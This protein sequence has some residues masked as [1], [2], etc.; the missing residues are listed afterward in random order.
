MIGKDKHITD[1]LHL[2][3][4]VVILGFTG[5]IGKLISLP[6][7]EMVWYRMLFAFI[8][9]FIWLKFTGKLVVPD[10]KNLVKY[11]ATGFIVAFHW[12]AFFGSI[13]SSTVSVALACFASTALFTSLLEPLFNKSKISFLEFFL[14]LIIIGAI[15]IIFKFESEYTLGII[16]GLASAVLGALF[17]VLNKRFQ[18]EYKPVTITLF[19]MAGGFIALS[20][21]LPVYAAFTPVT[22]ALNLSDLFW[23][24]ILS[25]LCTAY[26]FMASIHVMRSLSAFQVVL[27]INM[28]PVYG[29]FLAFLIFGESELMTPGF[30]FGTVLLVLAVFTYSLL[31][32]K[33]RTVNL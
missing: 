22:L 32:R 8:G 17:M 15:V 19:E 11:L 1:V 33:P 21:F 16:S 23:L 30:Y 9:L 29:I 31:K 12:V 2:H 27:T 24:L 3:F 26:A 7:I 4:I 25:L 10:R 28:E 6:A 13:K 20:V 14:G 18:K 5:V